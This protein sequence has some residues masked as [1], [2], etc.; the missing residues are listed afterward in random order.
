MPAPKGH[1]PYPGC[2]TG[3][4]PPKFSKEDIDK[5]ADELRVWFNNP[6]N[7]WY[8]DFCLE[9]DLDPDYMAEWAKKNEKFNGAYKYAK[10]KQ[11]SRIINGSLNNRYNS[12]IAAL[13]LSVSHGYKDKE[14]EK[15]APTTNIYHVNYGSSVEVLPKT[16]PDQDITSAR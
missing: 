11:K 3:G 9:K 7:V 1:P 16:I 15:Q 2:E 8:E 5:F 12:K 10:A 6:F 4:Q 13:V 14:E